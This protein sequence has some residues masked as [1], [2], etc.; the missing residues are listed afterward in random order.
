MSSF[1]S[2]SGAESSSQLPGSRG[3]LGELSADL[4]RPR[5]RRRRRRP[6]LRSP[7][8]DAVSAISPGAS[9]EVKSTNSSISSLANSS[10]KSSGDVRTRSG[11]LVCSAR[12]T[13]PRCAGGA[14]GRSGGRLDRP[15]APR[16]RSCRDESRR[17]GSRRGASVR[18]DSE[19]VVSKRDGSDRGGSD[20]DPS[21][22]DASGRAASAGKASLRADS[23]RCWS[24]RSCSTLGGT[25]RG[26]TVRSGRRG[27]AAAGVTPRSAAR[28]DQSAVGRCAVRGVSL[29]RRGGAAAGGAAAGFGGGVLGL[30]SAPS[31]FAN[32]SQ[33]FVSGESVI[34]LA[35]GYVIVDNG[36]TRVGRTRDLERL[37]EMQYRGVPCRCEVSAGLRV[38][39]AQPDSGGRD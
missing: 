11:G 5:R 4:P 2:D 25:A 21:D 3:A 38:M 12:G 27:G 19:R 37:P 31:S 16:P 34:T 28:C 36:S 10:S 6:V 9:V 18:G 14:C 35:L 17:G 26:G 1:V 29:V 8:P 7:S 22:R 33:R 30:T 13:G 23:T 15:E 20:R 32:S 39:L 24:T